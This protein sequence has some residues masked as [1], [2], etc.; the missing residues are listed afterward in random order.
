[1]GNLPIRTRPYAEHVTGDAQTE[2]KV[3]GPS[4]KSAH[5]RRVS[6]GGYDRRGLIINT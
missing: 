2:Y 6:A 1:L 4:E 5:V 3:L